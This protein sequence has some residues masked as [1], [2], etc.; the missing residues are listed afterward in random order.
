MAYYDIRIEY[1]DSD[2]D[3]SWAT[4]D[5]LDLPVT[6]LDVA[7]ENLRRIKQHAKFYNQRTGY[8]LTPKKHE[9]PE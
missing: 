6:S 5:T 8:S 7:K 3:K 4:S 9:R 2:S 1:T